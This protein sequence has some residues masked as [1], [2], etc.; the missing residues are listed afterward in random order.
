M[1]KLND[2][3]EIVTACWFASHR[4]GV[5][6]LPDFFGHSNYVK[7]IDILDKEYVKKAS[8]VNAVFLRKVRAASLR[9]TRVN[10][11]K[12]RYG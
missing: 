9:Q 6:P 11:V 1:P 2:E 4:R 8:S 3:Y 7:R 10:A 5:A 12:R